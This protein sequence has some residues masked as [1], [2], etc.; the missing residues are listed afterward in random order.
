MLLDGHKASLDNFPILLKEQNAFKLQFK[1]SLFISHDKPHDKS[2][3]KIFTHLPWNC[4][5]DYNIVTFIVLTAI[6]VSQSQYVI[7]VKL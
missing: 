1:E 6:F 7:T 2:R 5:V 4:L 3:T